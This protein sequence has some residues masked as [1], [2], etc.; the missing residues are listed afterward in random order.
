MVAKTDSW[1]PFGSLQQNS[2][3]VSPVF[4][5]LQCR[6]PHQ[7]SAMLPHSPESQLH[8][9]PPKS[10]QISC[11]N[12]SAIGQNNVLMLERRF[13]Q[14]RSPP[15]QNWMACISFVSWEAWVMTYPATAAITSARLAEVRPPTAREKSTVS[16]IMANSLCSVFGIKNKIRM[17][18]ITSSDEMIGMSQLPTLMSP[19]FE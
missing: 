12:P 9:S 10:P 6:N 1:G 16:G 18:T 11:R 19:D 15:Q 3:L 14:R 4:S 17:A 13:R 8:S 7:D 5:P 2:R